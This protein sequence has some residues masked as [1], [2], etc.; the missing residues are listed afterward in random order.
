MKYISIISKITLLWGQQLY[1][2]DKGEEKSRI[3]RAASLNTDVKWVLMM[4][5]WNLSTWEAGARG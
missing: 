2:M 4:R 3:R 5:S 1:S